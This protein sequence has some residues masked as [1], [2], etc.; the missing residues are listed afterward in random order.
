MTAFREEATRVV[1]YSD[2]PYSGGAERYLI[3]LAQ[4]LDP[5]RYEPCLLLPD[6][7]ELDDVAAL[8]V[9]AHIPLERYAGQGQ[10]GPGG[11]RRLWELLRRH[12]PDI[13]HLNLPNPYHAFGGWAAPIARLAGARAVVTTEH[14]ADIPAARRRAFLKRLSLPWVAR[15]ITISRTHAALLTARHGVPRERLQVIYNGV[16]DPGPPVSRP[17]TPVRLVC[18]GQIEGRKGQDLLIEALPR[19]LERGFDLRL[20]LVGDGPTRADL[21]NRATALGLGERVRFPGRLPSAAEELRQ[22]HLLLVPSRIEGLPFTILEGMAAGACVVAS[23]L[24][25]LD[26]AVEPGTS[27]LLLPPG[28]LEAWVEGVAGLLADRPRLDRLAAA[29]RSRFEERFRL[30]RMVAETMAVYD[31]ALR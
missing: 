16:E 24:P 18:V 14:I 4:G 7:R 9:A 21:M 25:G 28:N 6:R 23:A 17:A 29:G 8:A 30:T 3:R 13:V 11:L 2:A 26:E 10:G 31:R 27:G 1:Y 12:T 22:A 5:G 19:W 20:V 15:V